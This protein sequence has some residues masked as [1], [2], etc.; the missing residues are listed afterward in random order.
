MSQLHVVVG[1]GPVGR[2]TA[3]QLAA[4]RHEALLVSRSGA[5]PDLPGVRRAAAD[6][7][8]ADRLTELA[9]GAAALYNCVNPTDYTVWPTFWPPVAAAFLAA[10]ERT[11]A[12]LVTAS[13]LYGYGPVDEPMVEGMPDAATTTKAR[14]RADMWA[15]ARAAHEAGRITAVEVRGSDYMGPWVSPA[16]GHVARV[17]DAALAGKAVRVMGRPDVAHSFTD[18]RDM[19]RALAAVAQRPDAWGRVWHAPTNAPRTQAE[20]IADVCRAA[21]REPVRVRAMPRV[22]LAVGGTV[23]PILRELRETAYQF[24]RP[25]VLDSSAITRE[26]GLE[27]TPWAEV[28]RATATGEAEL[29]AILPA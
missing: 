3:A 21:G 11:G 18:V 10:A 14:L 8:D 6:A 20:A 1:A 28:C 23:V 29:P 13:C 26:L 12:T 24:T 27:P 25:Y 16:N 17:R 19:G 9:S 22:V 7:A 2:A 4:E 5:G 15:D